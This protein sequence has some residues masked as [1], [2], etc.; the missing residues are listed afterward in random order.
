MPVVDSQV[1]RSERV[2]KN[3]N[4]FK[5]STCLNKKCFC[6]TP[7]PPTLSPKV[8]KNLAVQFCGMSE[9]EVSDEALM[10]KRKKTRPVARRTT[11]SEVARPTGRQ[12]ELEAEGLGNK[13][14][15]DH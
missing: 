5:P 1:R 12:A 14:V 2:L 3:N 6:C 9:D 13:D 15:N 4:G 10:N 7:N 8:I 11:N